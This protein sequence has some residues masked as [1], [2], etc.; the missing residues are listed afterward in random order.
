MRPRVRVFGGRSAWS[1][2]SSSQEV[3]KRGSTTIRTGERDRNRH[4]LAQCMREGFSCSGP[5]LDQA[6]PNNN[7]HGSMPEDVAL[8]CVSG[9]CLS[10]RIF[11]FKLGPWVTWVKRGRD[12]KKKV[13]GWVLVGRNPWS[14]QT[15]PMDATQCQGPQP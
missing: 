3:R 15:E 7:V 8:G 10:Q 11:S 13:L 4:Q 6:K 14:S 9:G 5:Y 12:V 1:E 2:F